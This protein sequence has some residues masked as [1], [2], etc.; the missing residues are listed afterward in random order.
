[1]RLKITFTGPAYN[2]QPDSRTIH[3]L[4][5]MAVRPSRSWEE[6]GLLMLQR[7]EAPALRIRISPA[8]WYHVSDHDFDQPWQS[9]E[10]QPER[11]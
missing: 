4:S 8:G 1:M 7:R 2:D 6:A 5:I 11:G 3:V 10:I 9:I